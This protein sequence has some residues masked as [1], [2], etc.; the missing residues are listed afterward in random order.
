M[1]R[2]IKPLRRVEHSSLFM[3]IWRRWEKKMEPYLTPVWYDVLR[4][5][6][7][8]VLIAFIFYEA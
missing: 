1:K 2:V 4:V 7:W 6:I 5:E 3:L 8:I